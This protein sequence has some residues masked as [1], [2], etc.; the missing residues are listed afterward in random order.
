[1]AVVQSSN[2]AKFTLIASFEQLGPG[3]LRMV[4]SPD[5]IFSLVDFSQPVFFLSFQTK[6]ENGKVCSSHLVKMEMQ[7]AE[8]D[9]LFQT[10]YDSTSKTPKSL[11]HNSPRKNR[12]RYQPTSPCSRIKDAIY[13]ESF[14]SNIDNYALIFFPL[15]FVTFNI[16][17]WLSI[18]PVEVIFGLDQ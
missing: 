10:R 8:K 13:S 17:Y 11:F 5:A 9:L 18:L 14:V 15:C 12:Q 6:M 1:M 4:C 3:F 7:E 2:S 16:V